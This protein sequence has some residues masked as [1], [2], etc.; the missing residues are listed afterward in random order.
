[1]HKMISLAFV[2]VVRPEA[3]CLN[4]VFEFVYSK[5]CF[6]PFRGLSIS[7]LLLFARCV[8][9]GIKAHFAYLCSSSLVDHELWYFVPLD[10][11]RL[12]KAL[13]SFSV[14]RFTFRNSKDRAP[15]WLSR[16]SIRLL[17]RSWSCVSSVGALW[18]AL[19]WQLRA[20]T[21]LQILCPPLSPPHPCLC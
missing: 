12:F 21:L 16:L 15:G 6:I 2:Y 7:S 8:T 5:L 13:L 3:H 14:M 17:L 4:S 11:V 18:W 19:C 10:I 20:W 9:L 1:M